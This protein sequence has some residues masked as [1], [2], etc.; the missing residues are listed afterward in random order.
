MPVH[1]FIQIFPIQALSFEQSEFNTHSGLHPEYGS[2][3][4]LGRQLHIPLSQS[5]FEPQGDGWHGFSLTFM[6]SRKY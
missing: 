2:P 4:Y 5:A 6:S 3:K 1:G